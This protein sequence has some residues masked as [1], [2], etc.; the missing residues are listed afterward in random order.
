MQIAALP[1]LRELRLEYAPYSSA[2]L[3]QLSRLV[4]SLTQ[5]QLWYSKL[6]PGL[7]ALSALRSLVVIDTVTSS[8]TA[9]ER[10]DEA[11]PS[12]RQLTALTLNACTTS[13]PP[14]LTALS[15]L[16]A[17]AI[18]LQRSAGLPFTDQLPPGP[19][20]RSLRSLLASSGVLLASTETLHCASSLRL[21]TVPDT[22]DYDVAATYL[23]GTGSWKEFWHWAASLSDLTMVELQME[24]AQTVPSSLFDD[25]LV[26][27]THRPQVAVERLVGRTDV[28]LS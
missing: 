11:L 13:V 20:L 5:L 6:P 25:I 2:S 21:L 24:R 14:A 22:S 15:H 19:W 1:T 28:Y 26:L 16:G 18:R 12:L 3:E 17:L 7:S 23:G 8:D 4:P 27:K 9:E 10:L